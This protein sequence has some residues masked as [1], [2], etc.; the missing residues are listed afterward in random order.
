MEL[1]EKQLAGYLADDENLRIC[2]V[3][4]AQGSEAAV[5]ILSCVRTSRVGFT[6]NKNR[7]T[8]ALSR[9]QHRLHI[10]GNRDCLSRS[11][12]WHSVIPQ[13]LLDAALSRMHL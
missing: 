12:R 11:D 1:L 2:T 13:D 7:L 6:D 10:V 8:V 3:D 5:V 9:A 4:G